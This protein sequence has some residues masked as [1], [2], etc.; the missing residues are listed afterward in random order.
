MCKWLASLSERRG[1]IETRRAR[2]INVINY[3]NS[4][5]MTSDTAKPAHNGQQ[6]QR[7]QDKGL[8][9]AFAAAPQG[10]GAVET[11]GPKR[12]EVYKKLGT[13]ALVKI[14]VAV[15]KSMATTAAESCAAA[16]KL[17][18]RVGEATASAA[19]PGLVRATRARVR[20][21]VSGYVEVYATAAGLGGLRKERTR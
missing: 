9:G 21:K 17:I 15:L 8:F 16:E 3:S 6:Q 11:E 12:P 7:G 18:K 10:P 2:L 19:G 1:R 4:E 14:G 13:D 5:T 20:G